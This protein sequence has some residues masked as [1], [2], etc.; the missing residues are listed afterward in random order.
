MDLLVLDEETGQF[1]EYCQ[2]RK[3]PNYTATCTMSYANEMVRIFQ[4]I[5]RNAEGTGQ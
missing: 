1:M 3:H 5:V 4:G 2:L